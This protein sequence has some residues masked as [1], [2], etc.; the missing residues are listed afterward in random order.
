MPSPVTIGERIVL[1]L[2]QYSKYKEDFD[3]PV[4][5]SQDGIAEALRI[6]RAHAAI[7]L[8]KLKESVLVEE[9][10]AHIRRGNTKRKV[11]YL[12]KGGEDKAVSLKAYADREGIQI[13]PLLDLKKCQGP[14]LWESLDPGFRPILEQACVFRRPFKRSALP[15]TSISLFPE[16]KNGMVDIP[17]M[18]KVSIPVL[19]S[20]SE[21]KQYHSFA[22]DHWLREGNQRERLYHLV[23]SGR[24]KEAEMMVASKGPELLTRPDKDLSDLLSA[25]TAPAE[26]YAARVYSAQGEAARG[27]LQFDKALASADKLMGMTADVDKRTGT[28]LKARTLMDKGELEASVSYYLTARSMA[29]PTDTLLECD[30][31]EALTRLR[32]FEEARQCLDR[33]MVDGLKG[34]DP[35]SL[36]LV[37]FQLG[38][39]LF[40][41]GNGHEAI[42]YLSK[43][44]GLARPGDKSRI[45]Q[46]MSDA[47]M[48]IGMQEKSVEYAK[49][50]KLK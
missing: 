17:E 50:A 49:K 27:S 34:M 29:A 42:R 48:S 22:A 37:Y 26:K 32:R 12:N 41:S 38:S 8:K 7:E 4:D 9:R 28:C 5:V 18:L 31:A 10:I 47:Y 33:L 44:L 46:C 2:A 30:F 24:V 35:E 3:A 16:D 25:I 1:H 39:V 40:R 20:R 23:Q 43:A 14:E 11:Y 36:E 13:R 45:Y 21:L 19:A 6:S 15:E